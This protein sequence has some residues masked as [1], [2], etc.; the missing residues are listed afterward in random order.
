MTHLVG[1]GTSER[2]GPGAPVGTEAGPPAEVATSSSST[3]PGRPRRLAG[4]IVTTGLSRGIGVLVPLIL[5][6]ATLSYLGAELYGLWMTVVALTA[7]AAFADLGL[8]NG[9]MTKLAPCC[10]NRRV[11]LARSYISSAYAALAALAVTACV[12]LWTMPGL[13][14][15]SRLLHA[16]GTVTASDARTISV[17]CLTAFVINL[18]ITLVTRVQYA[19]QQVVQS[20]LWQAAANLSPL[21]LVFAAVYA[22]VSPAGVV[23][24]AASGPVLVGI[25]NNIWFFAHQMPD[26]APRLKYVNRAAI[27]EL[28]RLSGLFLA[29]TVVM[30]LANS[31]EVFVVAHAL[32][33][34]AVTDYSVSARLL[35]VLGSVVSILNLP[36]W[37]ANADALARGHE[38]WVRRTTRR[39]TAL[40]VLAILIPSA[41]LVPAGEVVL[42]L[43]IGGAASADPMLLLGFALWFLALGAVSPWLTVQLAA[44]LVRPQLIGWSMYLVMS[45]PAK[46]VG[47]ALFG[48][49]A[50]P[51]IGVVTL[52]LTVFPASV[53][54]YRRAL[55]A[56][57]G[58]DR[59]DPRPP[60]VV[61]SA[62]S[63][64]SSQ[65]D[66]A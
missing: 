42:R 43:W 47:V 30:A 61:A 53:L 19:Y 40:S 37:P 33:L 65:V 21:P 62:D 8:G 52:L 25:A 63:I 14:P 15:W 46:Y 58:A 6:P 7:M 32:D 56:L 54:G 20:N 59:Q 36:L 26:L 44:G 39:M 11:G 51:Y 49:V 60:A 41:V 57:A 48:V 50:V 24:A 17:V 29:L 27:R 2:R 38:G 28:F 1:Q 64:N 4:G 55:S 5:I 13:I 31:S 16:T 18:P 3:H 22:R 35:A 9:L 23:A 12:L 66:I 10:A 34:R 45:I